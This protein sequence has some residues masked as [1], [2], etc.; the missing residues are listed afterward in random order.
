MDL[1]RLAALVCKEMS[2]AIP[3]TSNSVLYIKDSQARDV[4]TELDLHIHDAVSEFVKNHASSVTL[5]SEESPTADPSSFWDSMEL[6][7]IDP[8]DGSNNF[9][10]S[11]PGYGFMATF[12]REKVIISSLA[13]IPEKNLYLLCENG[14]VISSKQLSR[15]HPASSATA[16]YAYTPQSDDSFSRERVEIIEQIDLNSAGVYRSGSACMGLFQLI[17]GAHSVF[18]GHRVR[19]WDV[20]AY[21]QIARSL[22]FEV[23]Y[24]IFGLSATVLIGNQSAIMQHIEAVLSRNLSGPLFVYE[25]DSPLRIG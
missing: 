5:L 25:V 3:A 4:V 12:I 23:R 18:V 9:A 1:L 17:T 11:L 22:Q 10:L 6:L 15:S 21:F 7:V 13:I 16:Y 20:L 19:V 2:V 8:L 14:T 24:R